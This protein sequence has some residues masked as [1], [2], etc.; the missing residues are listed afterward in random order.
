M[1]YTLLEA[2]QLIL[3]AMDSDSVDSIHDTIESEQVALILKSVYYDCASDIGLNENKGLFQLEASGDSALPVY[4]TIPDN[5]TKVETIRYNIYDPALDDTTNANWSML[6]PVDFDYFLGS[7]N[8]KHNDDSGDSAQMSFEFNG[9]TFDIMYATDRQ[10]RCFTTLNNRI[11]IFDAINTSI[12]TTLQ[13]AK[14][15]CTGYTWPVFEMDDTFVPNLDPTQF[16]YYLNFAK[17]RAFAELKQSQ[18]QESAS[19]ARRQKIIIQKRKDRTPDQP[20]ILRGPR[21]GRK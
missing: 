4:M 16:S 5:V 17:T 10:P 8:Q 2:V 6:E 7:M 15:M 19:T 3:S 1:K 14:T 13:K 11:V 20:A 9:Q 21:Y 18:N 12:D